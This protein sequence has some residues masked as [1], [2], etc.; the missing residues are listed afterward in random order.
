[1]LLLS[2]QFDFI[3]QLYFGGEVFYEDMR[4]YYGPHS[5]KIKGF[6]KHFDDVI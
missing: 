4:L 6:L 3:T 1:M 2:K 5:N